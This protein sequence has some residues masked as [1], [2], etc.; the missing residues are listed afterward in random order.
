MLRVWRDRDILTGRRVEVRDGAVLLDGRAIGVDADGHL[1]VQDSRGRV[2][3]VVVGE[4]R[5][6][7]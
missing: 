1:Q 3:R 7:E 5:M 4:V 2:F 6:V